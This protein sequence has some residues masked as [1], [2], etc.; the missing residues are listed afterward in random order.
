MS[1]ADKQRRSRME[2]LIDAFEDTF[3]RISEY[4]DNIT[5]VLYGRFWSDPKVCKISPA[6]IHRL[7][8]NVAEIDKYIDQLYFYQSSTEYQYVAIK[9]DLPPT[10]LEDLREFSKMINA[11]INRLKETLKQDGWT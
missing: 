2:N 6:D 7:D 4:K 11:T 3:K 8:T 5:E 9:N 10:Y 1:G